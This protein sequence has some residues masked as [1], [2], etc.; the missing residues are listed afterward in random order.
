MDRKEKQKV[1]KEQPLK[2][3]MDQETELKL[4]VRDFTEEE[5]EAILE[6][7]KEK[8]QKLS[9]EKIMAVSEV[10]EQLLEK[11][12]TNHQEVVFLYDMLRKKEEDLKATLRQLETVKKE[13][14]ELLN[15]L[16]FN[17]KENEG[18][19]Q[20]LE[21]TRKGIEQAAVLNAK[22]K[23]GRSV[24]KA[25]IESPSFEKSEQEQKVSFTQVTK[26]ENRNENIIA[27]YRRKHS[28]VEIAKI[29]G[30][31]QGEVKLVIDLYGH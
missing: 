31:G 15:R 9:N 21:E 13:K 5:A 27:L 18:L 22:S 12:N 4:L 25:E 23:G 10:S 29:M 24:K 2:L 16:E 30:M 28:I 26:P 17:T 1:D 14:E 7:I 8:L 19:L 3:T 6:E 11:I 20:K